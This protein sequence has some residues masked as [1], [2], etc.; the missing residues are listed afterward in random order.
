MQE[1]AR[2][3]CNHLRR[4]I[5]IGRSFSCNGDP[6]P[7][8]QEGTYPLPEAQL[9]RFMLKI[10]IT[11][12]NFEDERIVVRN[13]LS[14]VFPVANKV[15]DKNSIKKQELVKEIYMDEKIEKYLLDIV[16]CT[17]NPKKFGLEVFNYDFI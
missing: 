4:N 2:K 10:I 12:P 16:N 15:V 6:K 5:F 8:E 1:C 9:D 17:R 3:K 11:Y 13:N 14:K 7:V